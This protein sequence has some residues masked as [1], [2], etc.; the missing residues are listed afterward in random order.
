MR[1]ILVIIVA[2]SLRGHAAAAAAPS[3]SLND[4]AQW[5]PR[6]G[7]WNQEADKRIIGKGDSSLRYKLP[8]PADGDFSFTMTVLAGMRPR[9]HFEG[10]QL[11]I[12][13]EGLVRQIEAYGAESYRGVKFAYEYDQPMKIRAKFRGKNFELWINDQLMAKGTRKTAPETMKVRLQAGDGWSK[14]SVAFS[15][16]DFKPV[17]KEQP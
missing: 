5:D 11:M 9:V 6:S 4:F 10:T 13:N 2:I 14:G 17:A 15:D 3:G 7:E 16:F 8:L 1:V 12:G